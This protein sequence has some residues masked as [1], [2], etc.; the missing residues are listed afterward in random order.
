MNSDASRILIANAQLDPD[1]QLPSNETE[2]GIEQRK[3]SAL[4]TDNG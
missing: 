3:E 1:P 2:S 4:Q